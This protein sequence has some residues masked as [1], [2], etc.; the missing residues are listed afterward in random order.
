MHYSNAIEAVH[1]T[2]ELKALFQMFVDEAVSP[3]VCDAF[4]DRYIREC[5]IGTPPF[6]KGSD[7]ASQ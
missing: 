6:V 3:A 1:P 4:V 2:S 5:I 7:H